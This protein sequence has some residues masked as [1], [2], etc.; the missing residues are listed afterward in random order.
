MTPYFI[1]NSKGKRG[2]DS[3]K[4]FLRKFSSDINE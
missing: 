3:F 4:F 1:I 2:F